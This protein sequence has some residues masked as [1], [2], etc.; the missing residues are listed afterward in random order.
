MG[1]LP[2]APE[3][4]V[5]A[6]FTTSA[7]SRGKYTSS[8]PHSQLDCTTGAPRAHPNAR[9]KDRTFGL[10]LIRGMLYH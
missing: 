7:N 2:L 5:F 8:L 4:S 9:G 10:P 6:N 3:A 1:F